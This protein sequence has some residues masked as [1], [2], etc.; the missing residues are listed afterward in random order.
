[1][2][3]TGTP[4]T[5]PSQLPETLRTPAQFFTTNASTKTSREA[6]KL[7]ANALAFVPTTIPV[8]STNSQQLYPG[9]SINTGSNASS[10]HEEDSS[11]DESTIRYVHLKLKYEHMLANRSKHPHTHLKEVRSQLSQLQTDFLFDEHEA[12]TLY[13]NE[14]DKALLEKLRG[15]E[16]SQSPV[17]LPELG[18]PKKVPEH[19]QALPPP[20]ALS[21]TSPDIFDDTSSTD[22]G[23]GLLGLLDAPPTETNSAGVIIALKDMA[24]PP[25]CPGRTLPQALL[26]GAVARLDRYAIITY[27]LISGE[28]RAK[29]VSLRVRWGRTKSDTWSMDNVACVDQTQAEHYIALTALHALTFPRSEGFAGGSS[30]ASN[31]TF[32]RLLPP[33]FRDLWDELEEARKLQENST[34]RQV[35]ARLRS[36]VETKLDSDRKVRTSPSRDISLWTAFLDSRKSDQGSYG[37]EISFVCYPIEEYGHNV[38]QTCDGISNVVHKSQL[39]RNARSYSRSAIFCWYSF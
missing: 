15:S 8:P 30:R 37:K 14:R 23:E 35:W 3:E 7:D 5:P 20:L 31:P 9:P 16:S 29:R 39:P 6:S 24:L 2:Q 22:S 10:Q 25:N 27:N 26:K 32:F 34:N 11:D 4:Q 17:N 19:I 36:I 28:S 13:Q 33:K 18:T 12:A 1:M 38:Q 21:T